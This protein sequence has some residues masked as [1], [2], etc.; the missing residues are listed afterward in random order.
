MSDYGENS[1]LL[2]ARLSPSRVA[3][4]ERE[5]TR[6]AK[7]KLNTDVP[8]RT[9]AD[10]LRTSLP[11]LMQAGQQGLKLSPTLARDTLHRLQRSHGNQY[12]RRILQRSG[13]TGGEVSPE[14][15]RAI[16]SSRRGGDPLDT[17]VQSRMGKALDADF[18]G[19]RVHTGADADSLNRSL[20]A[21]AFTIGQ[22]V[23]FRGGE[24]N[25]ATSGG[26]ELLAHELTHVMQQNRERIQSKLSVGSPNDI[27]E[28]EADNVTRAYRQWE[29]ISF[30]REG[31]DVMRQGIEEEE[32]AE[33]EKAIQA[34]PE[35]RSLQRQ[36]EGEEEENELQM[37]SDSD[38][39]RRQREEE[40]T[41][42][43]PT[44]PSSVTG[45][46]PRQS[47]IEGKV[48]E[49]EP[50]ATQPLPQ[51]TPD[52]RG[53]SEGNAGL[54]GGPQT[55]NA[56]PVS[57]VTEKDRE[58]ASSAVEAEAQALNAE[59][60]AGPGPDRNRDDNPIPVENKEEMGGFEIKQHTEQE[61]EKVN[62]WADVTNRIDLWPTNLYVAME[63]PPNII[64]SSYNQG[65]QPRV[66]FNHE[67]SWDTHSGPSGHYRIN[68]TVHDSWDN[69]DE[70]TSLT[71]IPASSLNWTAPDSYDST[72]NTVEASFI[73]RPD[74]HASD[75]TV[76]A[77][78]NVDT[79]ATA[80][81]GAPT[82]QITGYEYNQ[83]AA[84]YR[85]M[86]VGGGETSG[87]GAINVTVSQAVNRQTSSTATGTFGSTTSF[88]S[89]TSA[90]VSGSIQEKD[91]WELGATL[92]GKWTEGEERSASRTLSESVSIMTQNSTSVT[93]SYN[94]PQGIPCA[95]MLVP[96]ERHV[97]NSFSIRDSDGN[98]QIT[99]ATHGNTIRRTSRIAAPGGWTAIYGYDE[100]YASALRTHYNEVRALRQQCTRLRGSRLEAKKEDIREKISTFR[101]RNQPSE[102]RARANAR[103]KLASLTASPGQ[104]IVNTPSVSP[105]NVKAWQDAIDGF[106]TYANSPT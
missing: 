13:D 41:E 33:E 32:E 88:G 86:G 75:R 6:Q 97:T 42:Q 10:S 26:R 38:I 106:W 35:R 1:L 103:S 37:K 27:Y 4:T 91:K 89:E 11:S 80:L 82:E 55:P 44:S 98:G 31:S 53:P 21:R 25:P 18:S 3:D 73:T 9:T 71:A 93:T 102:A 16:E 50:S 17:G 83:N 105:D 64:R 62:L 69:E 70:W 2:G 95:I 39:L 78:S 48:A 23:Y 51:L 66:L 56:V 5:Q 81:T 14:V 49:G 104:T 45:K 34:K 29:E 54:T 12:V 85:G 63:A 30:G 58:A 94:V 59:Q 15:E 84:I 67:H 77:R 99:E 101:S 46:T 43:A 76:R 96:V 19:V 92:G 22:D 74:F 36:E 100:Q 40:E 52:R 61:E 8:R 20:G 60:E 90:E 87:G 28:Q 24:Y 47:E 7:R 65:Y 57:E 72:S 79:F 68:G